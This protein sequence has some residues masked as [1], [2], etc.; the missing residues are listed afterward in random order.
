[1][2]GIPG[3]SSSPIDQ[4][5]EIGPYTLKIRFAN[6]PDANYD[7][8]DYKIIESDRYNTRRA[9]HREGQWR[10]DGWGIIEL[11][12]WSEQKAYDYYK[13]KSGRAQAR[14]LAIE[15]RQYQVDRLRQ[16]ARSDFFYTCCFA[17]CSELQFEDSLFGVES[18]DTDSI[19]T[20]IEDA[21]ESM[22]RK[23]Q[24]FKVPA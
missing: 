18:D 13:I 21:V 20:F 10:I 16:R 23:A 3:F 15:S 14:R 5:L 7:Q 2:L 19:R 24:S 12:Q 4:D 17:E 11:V 8:D 1:M 22:L 6:D 9:Q